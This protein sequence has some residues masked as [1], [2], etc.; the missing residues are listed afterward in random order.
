[1]GVSTLGGKGRGGGTRQIKIILN[2]QGTEV[3]QSK[4]KTYINGE[5]LFQPSLCM[6]HTG[7][8]CARIVKGEG[9][10]IQTSCTSN[11]ISLSPQ[12]DPE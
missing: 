8:P 5:Q 3:C 12:G 11:N 7:L 6:Q 10:A 4:L 2:T 1:M 9:L